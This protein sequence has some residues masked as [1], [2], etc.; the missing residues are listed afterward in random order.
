MYGL[1]S[2]QRPFDLAEL[3]K[4]APDAPQTRGQVVRRGAAAFGTLVGWNL[5]A[6]SPVLAAPADPRP[7]P[8]GF[9]ESF[10]PVPR[11]PFIHV[12]PPGIPFEMSTIT[13][14]RGVIAAAEVQGR[15][16]GSDGSR[17]AFDVDMRFMR[18]NYIAMDGKARNATFGFI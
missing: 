14:F 13:N 8:G 3:L 1:H 7:I 5:V 18:G 2:G 6:A 15:A 17:Y 10:N 9:D 12:L 16:R 4:R 11:D